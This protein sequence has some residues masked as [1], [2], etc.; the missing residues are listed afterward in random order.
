MSGTNASDTEAIVQSCYSAW[1]ARNV[2]GV[3]ANLSDR[4]VNDLHLPVDVV[5]FAGRHVGKAAIGHCLRAIIEEF[6]FLAYAVDWLTVDGETAR[7]RVVYYYRHNES[8]DQ[9]EGFMRR[10]WLVQ[11]RKVVGLDE[12]HDVA[13]VKAFLEMVRGSRKT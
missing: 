11:A 13:L 7:A 12:F 1:A 4:C 3:L 6:S 9:L 2:E 5:A 8:G 10:V